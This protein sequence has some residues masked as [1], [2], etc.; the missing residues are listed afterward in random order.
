MTNISQHIPTATELK[1]GDPVQLNIV[2]L[3]REGI[4]VKRVLRVFSMHNH[5]YIFFEESNLILIYNL[6]HTWLVVYVILELKLCCT[7]FNSYAYKNG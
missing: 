2:K 5:F 6:I 3:S 7:A 1:Y 4:C